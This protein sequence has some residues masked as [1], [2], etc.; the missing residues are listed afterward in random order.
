MRLFRL[1][2]LMAVTCAAMSG[3]LLFSTA[4]KVQQAEN[5]MRRVQG[6]VTQEE[7]TS[8]VLRAEWDY[9]NR[10][11]RLEALV[12]NNLDLQQARPE[13]VRN[14]TAELPDPYTPLI[15]ARKPA[16]SSPVIKAMPAVMS[17]APAENPPPAH[18]PSPAAQAP[19][20]S[21]PDI[22]S[23]APQKDFNKL[24]HELSRT[25]GDE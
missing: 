2:T 8:R 5:E 17:A 13:S 12:K 19:E 14:D 21:P 1:S 3:G 4:Q 22:S 20:S 15:P 10:P 6:K 25:G 18:K 16:Y 23:E 7:Q 9:L 24:L 11:D